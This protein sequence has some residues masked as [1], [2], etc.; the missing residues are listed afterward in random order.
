[1][2]RVVP[3]TNSKGNVFLSKRKSHLYIIK[4]RKKVVEE[5]VNK[6]FESAKK[7]VWKVDFSRNNLPSCILFRYFEALLKKAV[8]TAFFRSSD[9]ELRRLCFF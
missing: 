5:S 6:C 8:F 2:M 3:I 9:E 7:V 1:M 4:K